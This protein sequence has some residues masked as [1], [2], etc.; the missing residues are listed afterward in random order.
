MVS[1]DNK[2]SFNKFVITITVFYYFA[3]YSFVLLKE[4][5]QQGRR[6]IEV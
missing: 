6:K 5:R 2:I 3:K 1:Q 4:C